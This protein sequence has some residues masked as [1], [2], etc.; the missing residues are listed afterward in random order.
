MRHDVAVNITLVSSEID[1][2]VNNESRW[3][4]AAQAVLEFGR[5]AMSLFG[6]YSLEGDLDN[7]GCR[8]SR[9]HLQ[10]HLPNSTC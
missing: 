1:Q 3:L 2:G 10:D 9:P 4:E 8:Y 6:P 7:E 5:W